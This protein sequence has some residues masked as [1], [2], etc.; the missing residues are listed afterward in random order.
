MNLFEPSDSSDIIVLEPYRI[1]LYF[2]Y[3]IF[4]WFLLYLFGII[5]YNPKIAILLATIVNLLVLV[6]LIVKHL[7]IRY[8]SLFVIIQIILKFIPYLF[9]YKTHM[10]KRDYYATFTI[11]MIYLIWIY[12]G[13]FTFQGIMNFEINTFLREK[14]DTPMMYLY[15]LTTHNI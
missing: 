7:S 3:W 15:N 11:F 9:L 2:S 4:T 14:Y 12:A 5:R 1:D 8:I 13:G 10:L 6:Y